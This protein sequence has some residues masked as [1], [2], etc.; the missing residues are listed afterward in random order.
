MRSRS[1]LLLIACSLSA[2]AAAQ[3]PDAGPLLLKFPA[4]TRAVALGNAWVAGRDEDVVFYNPAQII[5]A[6]RGGFNATFALIGRN[7][8]FGS[9]AGAYAAG[10]MS[11]TLGWGVQIL[12]YSVKLNQR[13]P[14]AP[15][16]LTSSGAAG[17]LSVLLTGGGAIVLKGVR[18]GV[19]AKYASDRVTTPFFQV[20]EAQ[21]RHDALVA[22]VGIARNLFGGVLGF[23]AQN[24]RRSSASNPLHV[25]VPQQ[26]LLGWTTTQQAGQLDLG[27][28]AQVTARR[29]W[30]APGGGIEVGYGWIEGYSAALRLGARRPETKAERPFSLG[31]SFNGDHLALEYALQLFDGGHKMNRMTV[32][33]R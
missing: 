11:F 2:P 6:A 1:I 12:N 26:A 20:A 17:A 31:A 29:G 13:Y 3:S 25:A 23:S 32:R 30:L 16:V 14:F 4:S 8:K 27:L 21:P 19:T 22:D 5:S 33:W 15:D 7:S 9:M 24:L 18:V 28:A 10:P